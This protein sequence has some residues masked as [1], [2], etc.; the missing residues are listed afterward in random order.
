LLLRLLSATASV[1]RPAL[2]AGLIV[3][4]LL[5]WVRRVRAVIAVLLVLIVAPL[6][7]APVTTAVAAA[8]VASGRVVAGAS[9]TGPTTSTSVAFGLK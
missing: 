7:L 5:A 4:L 3:A 8:S 1:T 9:S 2:L 6:L